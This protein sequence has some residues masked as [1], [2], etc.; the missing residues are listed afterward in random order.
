MKASEYKV[1]CLFP[2][3]KRTKDIKLMLSSLNRLHISNIFL[4]KKTSRVYTNYKY[5]RN[6]VPLGDHLGSVGDSTTSG[7]PP[8]TQTRLAKSLQTPKTNIWN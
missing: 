3:I 1:Q 7:L 2:K 5:S 8:A 6:M 4:K